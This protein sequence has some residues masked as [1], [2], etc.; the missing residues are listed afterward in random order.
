M[1]VQ[2]ITLSLYLSISISLSIYLYLKIEDAIWIG[3]VFKDHTLT[4]NFSYFI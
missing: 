2:I 1:I 4:I 3:I